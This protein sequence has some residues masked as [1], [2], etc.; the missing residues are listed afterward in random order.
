MINEYSPLFCVRNS[1]FLIAYAFCLFNFTLYSL[2]SFH[3]ARAH[4][5]EFINAVAAADNLA[6]G[7]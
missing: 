2:P 4:I 3:K 7:Y 1:K 5:D 6:C